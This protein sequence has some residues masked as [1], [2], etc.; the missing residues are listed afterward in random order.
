ML[1]SIEFQIRHG[2]TFREMGSGITGLWSGI[3]SDGIWMRSLFHR[4]GSFSSYHIPTNCP[5]LIGIV[6]IFEF[7]NLIKSG[8]FD[9]QEEKKTFSFVKM[10]NWVVKDWL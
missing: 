3:T 8:H 9:F 4:A 10:W 6:P 1:A 7:Q 5:D 2:L